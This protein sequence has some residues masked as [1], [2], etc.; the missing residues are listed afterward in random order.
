MVKSVLRIFGLVLIGCFALANASAFGQST[1][2]VPDAGPAASGNNAGQ[3]LM[4]LVSRR[5]EVAGLLKGY[6]AQRLTAE[7][8]EVEEKS[9]TNQV[10]F[11][12]IQSDPVF[13]RDASQWLA[14]L[15]AQT[16]ASLQPVPPK[17]STKDD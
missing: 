8:I 13:A 15:A 4:Q 2:A 6:L 14:D 17:G 7:G 9:I 10:L 12:R 5:P 16:S 11:N 3:R 1:S